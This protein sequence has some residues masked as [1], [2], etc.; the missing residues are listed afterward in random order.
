MLH[1]III[2]LE[3]FKFRYYF[4]NINDHVIIIPN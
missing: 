2:K 3:V 4:Q 1:L